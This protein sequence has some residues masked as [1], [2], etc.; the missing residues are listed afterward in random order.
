MWLDYHLSWQLITAVVGPDGLLMLPQELLAA[1]PSDFLE[2]L[3]QFLGEPQL[4]SLL[5]NERSENRRL[6]APDC[7]KLQREGLPFVLERL[8][9]R[10]GLNPESVVPKN[11][12][13]LDPDLKSHIISCYQS[14]NQALAA[15]LGIDL[16]ALGYW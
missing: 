15:A 16:A 13:R 1:Q 14:S 6:L 9:A 5:K 7:W 3:C 10:L 4:A 2:S 8:I 12:L 11:R